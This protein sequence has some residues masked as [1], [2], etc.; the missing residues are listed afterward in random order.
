MKVF[1]VAL[2]A[3]LLAFGCA[4]PAAAQTAGL[5][6]LDANGAKQHLCEAIDGSGNLYGCSSLWAFTGS[7][8]NYLT[9]EADHSLDAHVVNFPSGFF[10]YQPDS[11][12]SGSIAS[13]TLNASY[14]VA[15][16]N[17]EGVV[18]F[19][20]AGLTASGATLTAEAADNSANWYP[21]NLFSSVAGSPS[22]TAAADGNYKV[23][24]SGHTAIRLRVSTVGTGSVAVTS[25]ASSVSSMVTESN[26]SA[27]KAD[28]DILVGASTTETSRSGTIAVG[29]AAQPLMAANTSRHGYALQNQSTA[30]LYVNCLATATQDNNSL[31]I[32]PGQLYETPSNHTPTGACSIIGP[33]TG[34][35][36][37]AREF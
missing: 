21:I 22:T 35:T 24:A 15:L 26:S 25:V 31:L 6:V 29:G 23:N 14:T 13:A 27:I 20:I 9:A 36:F 16:A 7:L 12:A 37:Y 28:L 11:L 5:Y 34:Q 19:N 30:N 17:A 33:T 3:M 32:T 8:P 2:C 4:F 1:R 10:V 18:G